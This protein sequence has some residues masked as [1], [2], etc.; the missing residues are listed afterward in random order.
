MQMVKAVVQQAKSCDKLY[1]KTGVEEEQ[2]LYSIEKLGLDR[3]QE[4]I[5]V[6][7]EYMNKARTKA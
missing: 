2:L 4:F 3:D 7:S 5:Q 6:M 1:E